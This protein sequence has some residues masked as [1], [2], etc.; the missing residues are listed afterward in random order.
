MHS[1]NWYEILF[2]QKKTKGE[3]VAEL[4][5]TNAKL[6]EFNR[7]LLSENR[8]LRKKIEN[9][10]SEN[11]QIKIIIDNVEEIQLLEENDND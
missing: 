5:T 1:F 6:R 3:Q 7:Q 11:E 2:G 9:L 10:I 4:L 8:N